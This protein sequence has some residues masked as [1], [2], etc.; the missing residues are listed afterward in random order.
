MSA[1]QE[2]KRPANEPLEVLLSENDQAV[3]QVV[4]R[5]TSIVLG[6]LFVFGRGLAGLFWLLVFYMAWPALAK[7]A[8]VSSEDQALVL[9]IILAIGGIAALVS[10]C[11]AWFIWRGSNFARLMVMFGV[12]ISI[13]TA[14]TGYFLNGDTITIHTTLLTVAFDI[15]VLLALSSRDARAWVQRPRKN[16]HRSK[17]HRSA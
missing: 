6:A 11:F 17:K 15:L 2:R 12:T 7:E 13:T 10:L 5:P 16:K 4:S 9:G 8:E 3:V 14:A 1:Q